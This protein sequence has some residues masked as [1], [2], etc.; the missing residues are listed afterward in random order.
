MAVAAEPSN[1]LVYYCEGNACE[2]PFKD[3]SQRKKI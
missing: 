2:N 1:S 3:Y